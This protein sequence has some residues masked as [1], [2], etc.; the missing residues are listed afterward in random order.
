[1]GKQLKL[2]ISQLLDEF[3]NIIGSKLEKYSYLK[4]F[5]DLY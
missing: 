2:R 4:L 1:M 5:K 3:I